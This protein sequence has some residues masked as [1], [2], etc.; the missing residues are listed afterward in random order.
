M[1]FLCN[2]SEYSYISVSAVMYGIRNDV[3][4]AERTNWL[5]IANRL[6]T[7]RYCWWSLSCGREVTSF[8]LALARV[9][10]MWNASMSREEEQKMFEAA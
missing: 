8:A 7:Q 2:K 4:R 5:H 1:F 3:I 6:V 10:F 9:L